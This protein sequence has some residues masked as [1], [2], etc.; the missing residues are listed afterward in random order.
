M[1]NQARAV[2]CQG[3][4]PA[5]LIYVRIVS[6]SPAVPSTFMPLPS[7]STSAGP[8]SFS[9]PNCSHVLPCLRPRRK[10]DPI[11]FALM[12]ALLV[13]M[14]DILLQRSPQRRFSK[15]DQPRQTF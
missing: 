5:S 3:R 13:V 10:Q 7:C 14:Y 15:Q 9:T 8:Q 4:F 12:V 1:I 2:F 6:P 11:V